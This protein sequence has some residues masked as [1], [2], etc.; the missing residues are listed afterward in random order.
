MRSVRHSRVEDHPN[1]EPSANSRH[2]VMELS[3]DD[4]NWCYL[5][6]S[7]YCMHYCS[8]CRNYYPFIILEHPAPIASARRSTA[9]RPHPRPLAIHSITSRREALLREREIYVHIYIYIQT[10]GTSDSKSCA[11]IAYAK[12]S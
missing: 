9:L 10:S 6:C 5:Y 4:H 11:C 3:C 7:Y 1:H 2:F 12:I 8:Y